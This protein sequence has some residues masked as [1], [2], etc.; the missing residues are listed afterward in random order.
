MNNKTLDE[1]DELVS[2][3]VDSF[4]TLEITYKNCG[5]INH[6]EMTSVVGSSCR[7]G[8]TAANKL[9]YTLNK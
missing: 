7:S 4:S 6:T 5:I 3:I 1:I 2:Q 8:M 9:L